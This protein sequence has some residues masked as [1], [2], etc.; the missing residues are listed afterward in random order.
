MKFWCKCGNVFTA[1]LERHKAGNN[2][3]LEMEVAAKC[4]ICSRQAE[5]YEDVLSTERKMF[6]GANRFPFQGLYH[7]AAFGG[8][9]GKIPKRSSG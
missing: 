4:P 8:A 6:G 1:R 7:Y 9:G 5:K 3:Q 2:L